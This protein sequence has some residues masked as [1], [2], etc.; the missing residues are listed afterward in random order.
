[1]GLLNYNLSDWRLFID[2]SKRSLKCVLQHN[3][4]EYASLPIGYSVQM[5]NE[6]QK[7][8]KEI[9]TTKIN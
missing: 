5:K 2:C 6:K 3:D 7:K 4:N 9:K 1:M 8:P